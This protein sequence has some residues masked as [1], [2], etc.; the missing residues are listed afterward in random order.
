MAAKVATS[1]VPM[2]IRAPKRLKKPIISKKP[3][4]IS[5]AAAK[6]PSNK[7]PSGTPNCAKVEPMAYKVLLPP[8]NLKYP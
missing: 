8:A 4:I 7:K 5:N 6:V 2:I 1:N 3:P